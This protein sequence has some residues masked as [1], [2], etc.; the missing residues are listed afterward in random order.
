MALTRA[1]DELV[2]TW[3][4]QREG[5][6]TGPSPFLPTV[7]TSSPVVDPPPEELRRIARTRPEADPIETALNE[8]RTRLAHAARID[9]AGVLTIRQIRGL[10]RDKPTTE[11]GIAA[12]TDVVFAR[13]HAAELIAIINPVAG[14]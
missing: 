1:A 13:R 14:H 6:S 10:L 8:W 3:T 2:I 7:L 9:A 4:D 5:K 11:E 12:I